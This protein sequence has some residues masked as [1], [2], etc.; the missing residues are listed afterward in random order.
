MHTIIGTWKMSYPALQEANALLAAGAPADEAVVEAIVRV[1]DNPNYTSVGY[2]GLPNRDGHVTLDAAFMDGRTLRCGAVI[3]VED[4]RNPIRAARLLCGRPENCV[5]AGRGAEQFARHAGLPM[6]DMR[7]EAGMRRWRE[8][9]SGLETPLD[10]YRGHD[11]V[12]VLAVDGSGRMAAGTSTSG[13]F[14][15]EAGR[16]GDTPLVGSGFYCDMRYGAAA[17]TGMGEDIMR[18]CLSYEIVSQMRRGASPQDAC[19]EAVRML[20]EHM[21]GLGET[22]DNISVIALSPDGRCGAATTLAAFPFAVG[23][24]A[25]TTL[26]AAYGDRSP[27][28]AVAPDEVEGEC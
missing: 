13:L 2:G 14:M 8:R 7:T 3:C 11:T 5:L 22:G 28:R 24:P 26:Y 9:V 27:V 12:C 10:A 20:A 1:E 25:S 18:G 21:Q 6:R 23:R 17:A 19:E 16:V 15:K 4:V